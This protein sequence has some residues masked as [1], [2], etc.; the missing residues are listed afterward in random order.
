MTTPAVKVARARV[1]EELLLARAWAQRQGLELSW[2]EEELK[3]RLPLEGPGAEE[4]ETEKYLL[5][6]EFIDYKVMPPRWR[7]VHPETEED[8]GAAA[9]PEPIPPPKHPRPS[10][11]IIPSNN[12]AVLC[13]PFNRLAFQAEGGP[14]GDWGELANWQNAS[15]ANQARGQTI[16]EMLA[17]IF[18]D[19]RHSR[20]RK[21]PLA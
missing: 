12:G 19:V 1:E 15:A 3:L 6:G 2:D 8:V 4:G 7:F 20:G 16:A 5:I 14:H 11:L 18:L 9:Y 13:A 10:P 21:G 17:A